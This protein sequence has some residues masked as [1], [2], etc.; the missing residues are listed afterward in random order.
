MA[1][2]NGQ[3]ASQPLLVAAGISVGLALLTVAVY[4]Q[5]V[6]HGFSVL[7]DDDYVVRNAIVQ[8]GLTWRGF[9]WAMTTDA[10]A[11]WHPLTWLSHMLDCQLFG[12]NAGAHHAVNLFFHT[13]NTVLLFLV[14]RSMT[15][16]TGR[17]ALV[18][19]LFAVHPLHV[20]S[21]A[22]IS[23]RK[24]VLSTLFWVL[25]MAAYLGYARRPGILR[26]LLVMVCLALGLMAKPMLVTLP[27]VLLLLDYWPLKRIRFERAPVPQPTPKSKR[28]AKPKPPPRTVAPYWPVVEKLPL[29]ALVIASSVV[30]FAV[31][32]RGG[33]V[34][35]LE[36]MT[37]GPRLA[38][39]VV[40]YARYLG[41]AL[42]PRGLCV[43]YPQ[44]GHD[45][46]WWQ[47]LGAAI[48]LV[49]LTAAVV[50]WTRRFP[51]LGV[52]W[53]W[54]LGTLVPVIGIVQVGSQA[55]AD[56]YM[57]V[58]LIG[59]AIIAAWGG[60]DALTWAA[61]RIKPSA[62]KGALVA[63]SLVLIGVLSVAAY[64]QVRVWRDNITLFQQ[65]VEVTTANDVGEFNLGIA[66]KRAGRLDEAREHFAEAV[67]LRENYVNAYIY[68]GLIAYEQRHYDEAVK[69]YN[70]AL[71]YASGHPNQG[72]A[73]NNLGGALFAQGKYD[74]AI[75]HCQRAVQLDP[76]N[77][78]DRYNLGNALRSANRLDE[79]VQ[80]FKEA[81]RLS[82][83]QIES[84]AA[85]DQIGK[86]TSA[87]PAEPL[88]KLGS[89]EE[90]F[91]RGNTLA[92]QRKYADAEA[93][94]TEALRLKPDYV[95]ARINLGNAQAVQGKL[96]DAAE[97]FRNALK[98]RPDS[99]DG[100]INLGNVLGEIGE[101]D[102]SIE[103]Y[104][105][106]LDLRPNHVDARCA[107]GYVL[108]KRGRLEPAIR[109]FEKAIALDPKC[110]KARAAIKS[111]QDHMN[112]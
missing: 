66:L 33:A 47:V 83:N 51:Y 50:R 97:Q 35:S 45:V 94:Y 54:F 30:T 26:Y 43:F 36:A 110:E 49:A 67:R 63:T 75:V 112:K 62:A 108:V 93:H 20:E 109:E 76:D 12:M 87:R 96:R 10:V 2:N 91:A 14:F 59:L 18:A 11:N 73:E 105:K 3:R 77:A 79:A 4:A 89:A 24:D 57:Y 102:G 5:V 56:R 70:D 64:T 68:L 37:V 48:L 9:V 74:E 21:V 103:A 78:D 99:A 82:P 27:C 8:A 17:S 69:H 61:Q 34:R 72:D 71:Q 84:R 81:L 25:A 85:L 39:A 42:W 15:G 60:Y 46:L 22:W 55:I 101:L 104:G 107:L 80:Q 95:D 13:L 86:T 40:G 98:L 38:N 65:T 16:A 31:Q 7:D 44:H 90:Y 52:G 100:W 106:A 41:K 32:Q 53:L 92:E 88:P 23:E 29:F 6:R 19:A 111:I 28:N 58:P 1:D